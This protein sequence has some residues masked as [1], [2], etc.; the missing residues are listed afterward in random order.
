MNPAIAFDLAAGSAIVGL[1]LAAAVEGH[2]ERRDTARTGWGLAT[3]LSPDR[4]FGI[5]VLP[6]QEAAYR[7]HLHDWAA[8]GCP[9][10]AAPECEAGHPIFPRATLVDLWRSRRGTLVCGRCSA[11]Q[12]SQ[13]VPAT[14]PAG[15]QPAAGRAPVRAAA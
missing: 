13:P 12:T 4:P 14:A 8:A 9:M 1:H 3:G 15:T 10:P 5:S 7:A 2:L 11:R 6:G